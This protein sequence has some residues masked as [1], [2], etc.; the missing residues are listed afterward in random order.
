MKNKSIK[1]IILAAL[2]SISGIVQAG[3]LD[4]AKDTTLGVASFAGNTGLGIACSTVAVP[5]SLPILYAAEKKQYCNA[6]AKYV[7][8]FA[9]GLAALTLA[10]YID[11]DDAGIVR[12]TCRHVLNTLGNTC[13]TL[14]TMIVGQELITGPFFEPYEKK[15]VAEI[16]ARYAASLGIG[17]SVLKLS[18]FINPQNAARYLKMLINSSARNAITYPTTM[19][20]NK[21]F[22]ITDPGTRFIE[23][24]VLNSMF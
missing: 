18:N 24:I 11:S 22:N 15:S 4:L 5:M 21:Y 23:N 14:P 7:K 13:I 17:F 12:S 19:I 10:N 20:F 8:P 16:L 6:L 9:A 1:K 2:L 3:L